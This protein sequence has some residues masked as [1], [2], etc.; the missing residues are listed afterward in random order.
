[1]KLLAIFLFLFSLSAYSD[2]E[3]IFDENAYKNFIKNYVATHKD[4]SIQ[5]DGKSLFV[6]R[7]NEEIAVEGGGCTHLGMSIK[8]NSSQ[9]YDEKQ[10]LQ[11]VL[12]LSTEFGDWLLNID[13]L[14]EAIQNK[15]WEKIDKVYYFNL[16]VMTVFE[17]SVNDQ[18]NIN[19]NFYIN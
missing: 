12:M 3:C 15:K 14:Q 18:G 1:M 4:S 16:N 8:L 9:K 19:V 13:E 11:K 7:Q 2:E 10:F 6:K 5:A 17:A